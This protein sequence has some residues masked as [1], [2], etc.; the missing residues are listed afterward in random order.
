MITHATSNEESYSQLTDE[1][2]NVNS[3]VSPEQY[4]LFSLPLILS[5]E[6]PKG[7]LS[8]NYSQR[9]MTGRRI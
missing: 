3:F 7:Y 6:T 8:Q 5:I 1:Q 2:H 4:L 9:L